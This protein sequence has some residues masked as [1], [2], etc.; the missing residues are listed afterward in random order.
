M[1]FFAMA[2][3]QDFQPEGHTFLKWET[4]GQSCLFPLSLLLLCP[5]L[6]SSLQLNVFIKLDCTGKCN[7]S[8]PGH[9][10]VTCRPQEE[11]RGKRKGHSCRV[12]CSYSPATVTYFISHGDIWWTISL[13]PIARRA[14]SQVKVSQACHLVLLRAPV[15]WLPNGP[16]RRVFF[17]F[18]YPKEEK[19]TPIYWL[20][21]VPKSRAAMILGAICRVGR[22]VFF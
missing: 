1:K 10:R 9:K 21:Y 6:S 18:L 16:S 8:V 11:R 4:G 22:K 20:H 7:E 15:L 19:S 17:V 2:L 3:Y 14:T 5:T 12:C 13:A